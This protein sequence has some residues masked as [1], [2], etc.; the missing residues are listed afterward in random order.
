MSREFEDKVALIVGAGSGI[1]RSCA[2]AFARRGARVVIAGTQADLGLETVRRIEQAAGSARFF[3]CNVSN[4]AEVDV[5]LQSITQIYGQLD[6][7][8][9]NAGTG[10]VPRLEESEDAWEQAIH[11]NLTGVWLCMKH[12][13]PLMLRSGGGV[14]V[15]MVSALLPLGFAGASA[16]A[17][18]KQ[19]LIGLTRAAAVEYAHQGIRVNAV[20]PALREPLASLRSLLQPHT[21]LAT[22]LY[23]LETDVYPMQ[24]T[25]TPEAV[26]EAVAWLC[27]DAAAC[28]GHTHTLQVESSSLA[29]EV[30]W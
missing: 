13:I 14:I 9:N 16:Y 1:A 20:C 15:N 30:V 23:T 22:E 18:S 5:L 11:I 26:A 17:A 6:F 7:A 29:R 4:S 21:Q 19:G 10:G 3:R 8:C 2:L 27:S 28:T 12:E 25:G 24:R